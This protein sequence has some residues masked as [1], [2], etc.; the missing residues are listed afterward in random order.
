MQIAR[1]TDNYAVAEQIQPADVAEIAAQGFVAV[2]CNRSDNEEPGQPPAA[3]IAAACAGAGI[4]FH[5]VPVAGMPIPEEAV[6]A[7]RGVIDSSDGPVLAYC[8]SGQ[9]SMVIWQAGL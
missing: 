1:L 2:I 8:R 5:H 4:T 9:R 7:H 3:A 6:Q